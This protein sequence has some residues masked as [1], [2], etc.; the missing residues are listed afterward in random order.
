[1]N[2]LREALH[3]L[4][5]VMDEYPGKTTPTAN[6]YAAWSGMLERAASIL[7]RASKE[8]YQRS[9]ELHRGEN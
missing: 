3:I 5:R 7:M 6:D 4:T 2:K 8:A 9:I 1:M